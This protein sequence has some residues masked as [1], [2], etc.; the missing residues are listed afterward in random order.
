VGFQA[1]VAIIR[2][3]AG[4]SAISTL[5]NDALPGLLPSQL[6]VTP[7]PACSEIVVTRAPIVMLSCPIC[8]ASRL[9]KRSI[10]SL[11]V[12][13]VAWEKSMLSIISSVKLLSNWLVWDV[14]VST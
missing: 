6:I 12:F 5:S 11:I 4:G 3:A 10:P 2:N 14:I 1:G 7:P 8:R 9:G 13:Q